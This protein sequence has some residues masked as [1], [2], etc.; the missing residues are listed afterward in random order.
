MMCGG[1]V[2]MTNIILWHLKIGLLTVL[3]NRIGGILIKL[4]LHNL[5]TPENKG[6]YSV[7]LF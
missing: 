3:Y 1:Q 6:K 7:Q 5:F 4:I 2:A